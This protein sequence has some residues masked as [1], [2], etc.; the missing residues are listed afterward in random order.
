[1]VTLLPR[2]V[3]SFTANRDR[4]RAR[5][6]A[7][8]MRDQ[9]P[10]LG[11][12]TRER[13][14]LTRAVLRDTPVPGEREL[15]AFARRAWK[16]DEREYQYAACDVIAAH[17]GLSSAGLLADLRFLI[18]HKSW[19]DTVDA[20]APSV[21]VL[22]LAHPQLRTEL[23]SWIGDDNIWV[24]RVALLHQLRFKTHTD[25]GRL[26]RYCRQRATDEEF[27]LRKAI[28]WALREYS[29]TDA[30]AVRRFV[31]ANA[32]RLSPLS[33]RE[34]LLWLERRAPVL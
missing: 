31:A 33:R 7:K 20:L 29:K 9:F 1:V 24:A 30:A 18:T 16:F 14:A 21:G 22:V 2:L 8:Y 23:D 28:G 19:W 27:F 25:S 17:V 11:I 13:R 4:G 10:F 3:E 34:A 5:A 6:M 32:D 15:A 12:P 26:F